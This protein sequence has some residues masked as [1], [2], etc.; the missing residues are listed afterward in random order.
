MASAPFRQ[1]F[2]INAD[3]MHALVGMP[4]DDATWRKLLKRSANAN[5]RDGQGNF[6][7]HKVRRVHF[8]G[9]MLHLHQMSCCSAAPIFTPRRPQ[10]VPVA[11]DEQS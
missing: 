9:G 6:L 1:G 11:Q 2:A 10:K 8:K 3:Q 5:A 7:L 4:V